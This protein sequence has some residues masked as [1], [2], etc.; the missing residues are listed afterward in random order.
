MT[1]AEPPR[2]EWSSAGDAE[3]LE[4]SVVIPCLNEADTLGLCI[5]KAQR[6]VAEHGIAGEIVVADNGSTDGS[7][8]IATQLGARVVHVTARGYG[9]P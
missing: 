1:S 5:S 2:R 9:Q 3:P 4:L 7:Q 8:E 6:A